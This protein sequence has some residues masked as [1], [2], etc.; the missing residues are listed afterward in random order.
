MQVAANQTS[1]AH[2]VHYG[3]MEILLIPERVRMRR[4]RGASHPLEN[5][6]ARRG[7]PKKGPATLSEIKARLSA[8]SASA[9]RKAEANAMRLI[10][11][12]NI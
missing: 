12:P 4:G 6:Q 2:S 7:A 9:L 10:K 1:R 3:T 8:G 5:A 11:R